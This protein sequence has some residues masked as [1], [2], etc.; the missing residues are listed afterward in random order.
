LGRH[1]LKHARAIV[2]HRNRHCRP[3]PLYT[4]RCGVRGACDFLVVV[5][6]VHAQLPL[7]EWTLRYAH[8]CLQVE[9]AN[10]RLCGWGGHGAE[11]SARAQSADQQK[12]V[13]ERE[14]AAM[15][16]WPVVLE[17]PDVYVCQVTGALHLCGMQCADYK[18]ATAVGDYAAVCRVTGRRLDAY[19]GTLPLESEYANVRKCTEQGE[20]LVAD[21]TSA[22]VCVQER[23]AARD[24]EAAPKRKN[25][26][27]RRALSHQRRLLLRGGFDAGSPGSRFAQHVRKLTP[28]PLSRR[29]YK[30][31]MTA[32]AFVTW[33]QE[34]TELRTFTGLAQVT[35]HVV[36]GS[37]R[38]MYGPQDQYMRLICAH[39]YLNFCEEKYA[40]LR[41]VQNAEHQRILCNARQLDSICLMECLQHYETLLRDN[42]ADKLS[43]VQLVPDE[44][45]RTVRDMAYKIYRLWLIVRTDTESGRLA[46]EAFPIAYFVF[47][48]LEIFAEGCVVDGAPLLVPDRTCQYL[49]VSNSV[50]KLL[51]FVQARYKKNAASYEWTDTCANVSKQFHL[52]QNWQKVVKHNVL[53]ALRRAVAKEHLPFDRFMGDVQV[54]SL[55][56]DVADRV[57]ASITRAS[58]LKLSDHTLDPPSSS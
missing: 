29:E 13:W 3:L 17:L 37:V 34:L 43:F 10:T 21:E 57:H 52:R 41:K 49:F 53:F 54:P 26:M 14:A 16:Q 9:G 48:A 36:H 18:Y 55:P 7:T 45:Q 30:L 35:E 32:P 40:V 22:Y 39:L 31:L 8:V 46:P 50:Y 38:D 5:L 51:D 23:L 27:L 28:G 33:M 6:R 56:D 25:V 11:R 19:F 58:P 20:R 24:P 42:P 47:P 15:H 44:I 2:M 12:A 1:F 4:H